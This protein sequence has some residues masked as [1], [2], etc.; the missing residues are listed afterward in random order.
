M[1]TWSRDAL[2][3]CIP[4]AAPAPATI[5]AA[6]PPDTP[7]VRQETPTVPPETPAVRVPPE[8][9]AAVARIPAGTRPAWS[10]P[11][12]PVPRPS[13]RR[14]HCRI[15]G[16]PLLPGQKSLHHC[17]PPVGPAGGIPPIGARYI[18]ALLRWSGTT[19]TGPGPGP[20]MAARIRDRG[21]EPFGHVGR[22]RPQTLG[23]RQS[24]TRLGAEFGAQPGGG[25][26]RT[27]GHGP[28]RRTAAAAPVRRSRD[29]VAGPAGRPSHPPRYQPRRQQQ[30]PAR[31][32]VRPH[33]TLAG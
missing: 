24:R 22:R 12:S 21:Q 2:I 5:P 27:P 16:T 30:R 20:A 33:L 15:A 23:L 14:R 11:S 19:R 9:P 29:A 26:R 10:W 3:P 32:Q 6:V 31:E 4:A 25:R 1:A 7:G 8:T 28:P 17:A 13:A 18:H